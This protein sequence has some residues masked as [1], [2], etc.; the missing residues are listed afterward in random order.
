MNVTLWIVQVLLAVIF[1]G[2]GTAKSTMRRQRLLD[3]G[4]TGIAVYPMRVVRFTAWCELLGAAGLILPWATGTA[5][6]LTPFAAV[7]LCLVMIGAGA[8]H[9]K[10]REYRTVAANAVIFALAL[11]VAIARFTEL[12]G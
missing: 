7:G 5:R 3:T 8:A 2:S 6:I 4:Q 11:T 1:V 12:A 9:T 10:L